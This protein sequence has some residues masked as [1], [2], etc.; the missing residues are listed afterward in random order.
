MAVQLPCR[1]AALAVSGCVRTQ[2]VTVARAGRRALSDKS[3][4]L[5]QQRAT[6]RGIDR[7]RWRTLPDA[8]IASWKRM[9]ASKDAVVVASCFLLFT[10]CAALVVVFLSSSLSSSVAMVGGAHKLYRFFFLD[11]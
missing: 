10:S 5:L 8:V 1:G 3:A 4:Q 6:I 2:R 9:Q 7:E 11:L